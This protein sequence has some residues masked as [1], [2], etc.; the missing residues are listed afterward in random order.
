MPPS[1]WPERSHSRAL[2]V[3]DIY[4]IDVAGARAAGL[5]PVLVDEAGLYADADCHRI[6]SIAELPP[7][8]S[9]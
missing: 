3:G 2:H 8:L 4:H 1:G 6:R 9:L 5:T 7:L